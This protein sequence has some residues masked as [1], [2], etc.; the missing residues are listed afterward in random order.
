MSYG[1]VKIEKKGNIAILTID[2][3]PVNAWNLATTIDFEKA[4]QD[5][6]KDGD[7]RVVILTG[8]GEKCFSAGFDLSDA[9]N[10]PKIGSIGCEVWRK[11]D[12]FEKPVIAAINGFALGGG[13]ELALCCH[14]RIMVEAPKA[15]IGLTELNL[16]I[17]PG[18][19][20]TQ[21]LMN[22]IGK[23]KALDMILF[24]KKVGAR[25]ALEF[26]LINQISTPE[27]LM[28]DAMAF[29]EKLAARPPIAVGAVLKAMSAGQYEG[30]D[31]GLA[32]EL[33]GSEKVSASKDSTEGFS[34]FLEK[35]AP[36]FTGE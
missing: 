29:A 18:L 14:F 28:D 36:N 9:A 12:R 15:T 27:T 17:L 11:L 32:V 5:V 16:G 2:H 23:A 35:R 26:G 19:G 30:V 3:P 1:N 8:A 24:S 33:E 7:V 21:R 4:V 34:A 31:R 10:G 25:E 6:E 20:G 22:V 13:L